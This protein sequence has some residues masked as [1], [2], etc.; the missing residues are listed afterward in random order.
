[1]VPAAKCRRRGEGVQRIAVLVL[2]LLLRLVLL[3]LLVLVLL[4]GFMSKACWEVKEK[5][6]WWGGH[7]DSACPTRPLSEPDLTQ[8][9]KHCL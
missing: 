7:T 4:A 3:V 8:G 1:M 2:A 5:E 9:L 6:A